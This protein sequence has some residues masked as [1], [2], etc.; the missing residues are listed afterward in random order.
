MGS[1]DQ[2]LLLHLWSPSLRRSILLSSVSVRRHHPPC[3]VLCSMFYTMLPFH[4]PKLHHS[5]SPPC[6]SSPHRFCRATAHQTP[7]SVK[8]AAL[9]CSPHRPLSIAALLCLCRG[10][11]RW[12]AVGLKA[13]PL[14]P[15]PHRI[16]TTSLVLCHLS[17]TSRPPQLILPRHPPPTPLIRDTCLNDNWVPRVIHTIHNPNPIPSLTCRP[18]V[19]CQP[20]VNLSP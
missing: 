16:T 6:N 15:M 14:T 19:S 8:L 20:L 1:R 2:V 7:L 5:A 12:Q 13:S 3:W 4:L 18:R 9:P 17:A 11:C 10:R